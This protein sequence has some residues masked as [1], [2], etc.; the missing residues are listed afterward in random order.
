MAGPYTSG[1]SYVPAYL[2]TAAALAGDASDLS[3]N[4]LNSRNG[5]NTGFDVIQAIPGGVYLSSML[6]AKRGLDAANKAYIASVG[7]LDNAKRATSAAKAAFEQGLKKTAKAQA[8]KEALARVAYSGNQ[9]ATNAYKKAARTATEAAKD[10]RQEIGAIYDYAGRPV[11]TG[12]FNYGGDV[13]KVIDPIRKGRLWD[14]VVSSRA[15]QRAAQNA[16]FTNIDK[17]RAADR[18]YEGLQRTAPFITGI[19]IATGMGSTLHGG[20]TTFQPPMFEV[21]E[22]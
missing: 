19:D 7:A 12:S 17:W 1:Y 14:N 21:E 5:M 10:A 13:I 9:A 2:M 11:V 20:M 18:A 6:K 3:Q 8:K 4:G 22:K 16:L 15:T